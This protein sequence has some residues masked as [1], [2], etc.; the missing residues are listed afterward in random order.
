[1]RTLGETLSGTS[2]TDGCYVRGPDRERR[3]E[4]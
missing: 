2:D 4:N 1:M 3:G